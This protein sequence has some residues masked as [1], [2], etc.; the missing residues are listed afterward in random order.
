MKHAE[1]TSVTVL[2]K[3]EDDEITLTVQDNGKGFNMDQVNELGGIG[4]KSMN[5]RAQQLNGILRLQTKPGEGVRVC[6]GLPL[7]QSAVSIEQAEPVT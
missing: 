1:A 5:E 3:I 4:L 7:K 6:V 2:L